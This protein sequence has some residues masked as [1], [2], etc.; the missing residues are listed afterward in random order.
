MS[1]EHCD[2]CDMPKAMCAHS[3]GAKAAE[4][5]ERPI[6]NG[7]TIESVFTG[8]CSCC[9]REYETGTQITRTDV[10]WVVTSHLKADHPVDA[11]DLFRSL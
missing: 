10:G 6:V 11:T 1:A 2:H 3:E 7:P 9:L 5:A 8:H 4:A